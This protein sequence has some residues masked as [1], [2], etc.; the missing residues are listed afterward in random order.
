MS[1][2]LTIED[3]YE[4]V[5]LSR[6]RIS[7]DGARVAYV[8]TE[9]DKRAHAYRSAIWVTSIDGG[10]AR[11]VTA[12]PGN[13]T[14]PSWSPDGKFLAFLS[15]RPGEAS[16]A[17]EREQKALGKDKSQIWLLPTDGGEG[18]QLTFMPHG[19]SSPV[20]SPDGRSLAFTA[21]VGPLDEETEDGKPLP[22]V[23]VIDRLWYRLDGVGFIHDRR[24][25]LFLLPVGGGDAV[26]LTDGDWD[27]GDPAWAP[28]G[29]HLAFVSSRQEDRWRSPAPDVYT[30]SVDE[31]KA[32]ALRRL[33]DGSL[34]CASPA[35]SPDG[36]S[37]AFLGA[38]KLR[39]AG[40]ID[41][42]TI[43]A[44]DEQTPATNLT[45]EFEGCCMDWTNTDT[46]ARDQQLAPAPIWSSDGATLYALACRR[47]AT[48]VYALP[49]TNPTGPDPVTL[50]PG[51]MHVRDFSID[52]AGQRVALLIGT[53]TR[54]P[55]LF[56]RSTGSGEDIR[57]LTSVNE[58]LFSQLRL[59]TLEHMPFT[60]AQDWPM[61]GWILKPADFDTSKKYPLIV[62]IHGGPHTQYGY[63][64]FHEMQVQAASG[65]VVLLT[66]PRGSIGYGREFSLAVRGAWGAVDSLDILAGVDAVVGRGYIDE[67]RIG[68][69]GG[70]YG[71]FMTNWL[72]GHY[73]ERFLAAVTDRSVYNLVSDFGSSDFGWTFA[74]DELE[75][76]PWDDLDRYLQ[77]SPFTWV[78]NIRT[79]LL[80]IHSEQDLRCNIE[81][82]EELFAALK[83]L[84]REVLLV[85]FEGQSHGLSR[86][87]HPKLRLERLRHALSWFEKYLPAAPASAEA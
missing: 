23:R 29:A 25:H 50:T 4:I 11:R 7:P 67:R 43:S 54:P 32:G 36:R 63:G 75:V 14:D 41:V 53:P 66:N 8:A 87:G 33:T 69:T 78:R 26:Q 72:I 79:P 52:K 68:V 74:D 61:E 13:A 42:Y 12:Q 77:R 70:S 73:P 83:Y 44:G 16:R 65:Y 80:I 18:H 6:P 22:K 60:G 3:L 1:R 15:D 5:F 55:E 86:G 58:G 40:Q 21:L 10:E 24:S 47:G 30:L 85:R 82:A 20:W 17:P 27:D 81:Q 49:A 71:G 76:T 38:L 37:I 46:D 19:A 62:Q 2:S 34:S 39:S 28:S 35:W 59:A 31:G 9:I 56:A 48:R 57:P 84:G 51:Q 45:A 64:F